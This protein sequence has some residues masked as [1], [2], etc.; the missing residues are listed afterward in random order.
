MKT[1][2]YIIILLIII[3]CTVSI[4]YINKPQ[5]DVFQVV[6]T[7]SDTTASRVVGKT[8][9]D[10]KTIVPKTVINVNK[11]GDTIN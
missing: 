4:A 2:L 10:I 8:I 9:S 7:R 5:E 3:G 11:D 1:I 6:G